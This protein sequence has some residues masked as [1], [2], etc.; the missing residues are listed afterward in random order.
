MEG[1]EHRRR[2]VMIAVVMLVAV[3]V[4]DAP[5]ATH[6]D[7]AAAAS[8][9]HQRP[10]CPW[11]T[12]R[13][14]S[15]ETPGQLANEVLAKMNAAEKVK[16][17]GLS[18]DV[19]ANIE[20]QTPAI[21]HLCLPSFTLRD[22]PA[23]IGANALNTTAFPAE[24]NLA[25]SFDTRL[26]RRFGV[27]LGTQ[28]RAQGTMAVQGPGLDPSVYDNWGR[29]FENFGDDPYLNSSMGAAEVSGIQSAGTIAVAKHFGPYAAEDTRF[30][31]N[32]VAS[33]RELEQI[34]LAPFRAAI[35]AGV[36]GLMCSY[37]NL[38]GV[39]NCANPALMSLAHS[40]GF[41]GIIR[42]D[43]N[44]IYRD[45]LGLRAGV[46]LFKTLRPG[47]IPAGLKLH[48][49]SLNQLNQAVSA[50]LRTMFAYHD[51][52]AIAGGP[53]TAVSSPAS[54]SV[55]LAMAEE[56]SV[57]LKND[58]TLPLRANTNS[59]AMIS[60]TPSDQPVDVGYGSSYV[61][62]S[63]VVT[64]LAG[65]TA[66]FPRA[67][68]SYDQAT[69]TFATATL[70]APTV[71]NAAEGIYAASVDTGG[72][73]G[74]LDFSVRSNGPT[75]LL[76]NGTPFYQSF[77]QTPVVTDAN[78]SQ[79]VTVNPGDQV[80]IEWTASAP[81]VQF[82]VV[83]PLIAQAVAQARRVDVPIVVVAQQATEGLDLASLTLPGFQNQ[84][85]AAV[86]AAN[87]R[88]I[89]VIDSGNP[90]LMPWID[91][92]A[93]VLDN[94]YPGEVDGTALAALIDG[95]VN[96]SG[97]LPV[98][99]PTSDAT[100][101]MINDVWPDATT[102]ISLAG[103]GLHTGSHW[104]SAH[105]LTPLFPYGFGLS[106]T[107]FSLSN[108]SVAANRHG[109]MVSVDVTNDGSVAGRAVV[110]GYLD[111]PVGTGMA[112]DNLAT[113]GS[114]NLSANSSAELRMQLP[115]SSLSQWSRGAMRVLAGRYWLKVG[116]SSVTPFLSAPIVVRSATSP[117][118]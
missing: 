29:F 116:Q 90:I 12:P 93:A 62:G 44:A 85:V 47:Q 52:P 55:A 109:Y 80:T 73:T 101:P 88:T 98:A 10:A 25:S 81:V 75:E 2:W 13:E 79:A 32:Y 97:K 1:F 96:P 30:I 105:G 94:W 89:V 82:E 50:I 16:M 59:L 33:Q 54:T 31:A 92:V 86:A 22:G 111:F 108:L 42:T 7:G 23:G 53:T 114:I 58:G 78:A 107:T 112:T 70:G 99:I 115:T 4:V 17:L 46:D 56:G 69:P 71:V 6:S 18:V 37:G 40:W 20:N 14:L 91:S 117:T 38:N 95:S 106:Y 3:S 103:L 84:L 11:A 41:N 35:G 113:F 83:D 60:S 63:P 77:L 9:S 19:D 76:V 26:A 39:A 110:Q 68:V 48:H 100:A 74:T 65:I 61:I 118:A 15:T 51:V 87:P 49:N 5:W 36:S 64:P 28:A 104:Y 72:A 8:S 24:I 27:V 21:A 34:Y 66:A 57:L 102:V 45:G 43:A 67:S